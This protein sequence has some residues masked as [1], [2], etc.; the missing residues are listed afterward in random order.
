MVEP[1]T[2]SQLP[3]LLLAVLLFS[4]CVFSQTHQHQALDGD[5]IASLEPGVSNAADVVRAMGAPTEVV[6]LGHRS[7]YR[8]DAS[9]S[10]Q[11]GLFLFLLSLHGGDSQQDRAWFFFDESDRLTH[12]AATL[13]AEQARFRLP[14]VHE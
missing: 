3:P 14:I 2:R 13:A 7:A 1:M 9:Q 10:K 4:S 5:L 8:Y 12:R 11:A 6:Q